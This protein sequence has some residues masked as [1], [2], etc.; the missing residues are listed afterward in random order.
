MI[1][2]RSLMDVVVGKVGRAQQTGLYFGIF[3]LTTGLAQ[4][5]APLIGGKLYDHNPT[6]AF[7][8]TGFLGLVLMFLL[9]FLRRFN[10]Q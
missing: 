7:W 2:S 5:I 10:E 3:G 8:I 6:Q 4:S 1:V 9:I